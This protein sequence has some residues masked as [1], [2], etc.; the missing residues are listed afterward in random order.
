[1]KALDVN[2]ANF[3]RVALATS[4]ADVIAQLRKY[5]EQ[6]RDMEK[7][8][9]SFLSGIKT[10]DRTLTPKQ[11]ITLR[12]ARIFGECELAMPADFQ[13]EIE[14]Y[15]EKWRSTGRLSRAVKLANRQGYT[16]TIA[17]E[18]LAAGLP[19]QF[20]ILPCRRATSTRG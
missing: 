19:P 20:F 13:A 5:Q 2:I 3:E 4:N 6:R 7:R 10:V 17:G 1:M 16:Q 8:Y 11:R 15:I 9:T 12:V 14:K 18:L